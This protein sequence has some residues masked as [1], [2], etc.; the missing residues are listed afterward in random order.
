MKNVWWGR[1][2]AAWLGAALAL[3]ALY[4]EDAMEAARAACR[5][6]AGHVMP[7]L[8][9]YM[10]FSQLLASSVRS[11]LLTVPLAMLGGSPSGARL[12]ALLGAS[13]EK[14]QRLAAL[15]ATASPLFILGTLKGGAPMLV[16]HWLGALAAWGFVRLWGGRTALA[17]TLSVPQPAARLTLIEAVRDAALAML[18]V[19]GFMVL[20]SVLGALA[21]HLMPLSPPLRALLSCVLEMAG[22]C[23]SVASLSLPA[24]ERAALQCA[25]VSFGGLSVFMQ[26]ALF[27][28]SAGVN[29]RTQLCAR[30]VHAAAAYGLMRLAS[31]L[32]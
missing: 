30:I 8:F 14:A 18:S 28:R 31:Y 11:P 19:C 24:A 1:L 17:E 29:L 16:S 6:W 26:N 9:P 20:F 25:A 21:A 12:I 4:P 10:V 13:P 2:R 5:L 15:C 7:A 3:F 23:A 27:L 32:S 22:G